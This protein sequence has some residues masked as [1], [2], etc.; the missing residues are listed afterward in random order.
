MPANTATL[1]ALLKVDYGTALRNQMNDE[2]PELE[3]FESDSSPWQGRE[4]LEAIHVNRNRG[5]YFSAEGGN[6][7]TAGRQQVENLRIPMRYHHGAINITKQLMLASRSNEGAFA[8][9]MRLE[10]DRLLDDMRTQRRFAIWGDGR[11]VRALVN[12]AHGTISTVTVDAPGGIAGSTNGTRFIN[13]GDQVAFILP[14]TG[15]LRA[16]GTREVTAVA[17]AGTSFT[18]S[19]VLDTAVD[20][21][22]IIVKAYGSDA[23]LT[24]GNTDY[25]HAPMGLTGLIDNATYINLYFGLSRTTF[26]ILQS[27]VISSVGAL[28]ADVIQRAIDVAQQVGN[29]QIAYHLMHP[30]VVRAYL[31]LAESDRRY[32]GADLKS[33]DVGTVAAKNSWNTGL[34]F[35]GTPLKRGIDA[36]YGTW[37]GVDPRSFVRYVGDAGSWVDEDGAV[38]HRDATAVD[39]FL[40]EYRIYENF[41]AFRP[42]QSF[43]LDGITATVVAAHIV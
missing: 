27:T 35:G 26:P 9:G 43:R 16:G 8:R 4:R 22:D 28:S 15:A 29:C 18:V 24:V 36:P 11:G 10:M 2:T 1:D 31:A 7:P 39:T 25:N 42:N 19:A 32:M 38:L 13:V 14:T 21:N 3:L 33:P 6:I 34:N 12:G 23:S 40:G 37:F 41:C 17:A 20:D 30:S 5:S